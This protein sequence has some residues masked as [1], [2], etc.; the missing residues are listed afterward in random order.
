MTQDKNDPIKQLLDGTY[1]DPDGLG[2]QSVET[3][4]LA[5]EKSLAGRERALVQGLG[6][7]RRIA[8]V[9]DPNTHRVLGHRV[10]KAL[11]G[12]FTIHSIV[13]PD[14]PHPDDVTVA[15]VRETT[16]HDD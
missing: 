10:E 14:S 16:H 4:S 9:S 15:K 3:K 8:V 12:A 7:G 1:A 2:P 6:L 13:F 5:I 11:E